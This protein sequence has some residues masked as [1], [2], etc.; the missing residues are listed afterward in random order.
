MSL[1]VSC[2]RDL[3]DGYNITAVLLERSHNRLDVYCIPSNCPGLE[4]TILNL[5][6]AL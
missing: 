3:L 4:T 6:G 5:T 2:L 1:G